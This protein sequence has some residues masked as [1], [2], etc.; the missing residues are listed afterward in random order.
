MYARFDTTCVYSPA[1]ETAIFYGGATLLDYND[2]TS[3]NY[4]TLNHVVSVNATTDTTL[5]RVDNA[6]FMTVNM[7]YP[8]NPPVINGIDIQQSLT[9]SVKSSFGQ[10]NHLNGMS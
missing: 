6:G 2:Y 4:S 10:F 8:K 3:Y 9:N 1:S 5:H 7:L